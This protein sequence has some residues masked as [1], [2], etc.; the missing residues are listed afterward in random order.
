MGLRSAKTIGSVESGGTQRQPAELDASRLTITPNPNPKKLPP[1]DSP[2]LQTPKVTTDHRLTV[3][4]TEESGWDAPK[5]EPYGPLSLM[6][7]ASVLHYATECYEGLKAYRGYDGRVRLFR[8]ERNDQ[9]FLRSAARISLPAF[10]PGE[11]LKLLK[12]FVG[13]ETGKWL[14]APGRFIYIRPTLIGTAPTLGVNRPQEALMYI[15]LIMWPPLHVPNP[16]DQLSAGKS[17]YGMKLLASQQDMIRAWPGGIG[18][19]KVGANYGPT[20]VAHSEA[21]KSGYDQVLWLFGEECFV[22]EA[23]GT[24]MFVVFKSK[25]PGRKELVTPPLIDGTILEGV[26]RASVLD[27]AKGEYGHVYDVIERKLT[28]FELIEAHQDGRL[29][30]AFGTGTAYFVTSCSEIQF[31][32]HKIMVPVPNTSDSVAREIR[33]KLEDIMYGNVNHAWGVEVDENTV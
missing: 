33:Q 27:V 11:F 9:R 29:L 6:P 21:R 5:I 26:T 14:A 13:L 3:R 18:Y 7:T 20:F 17:T 1:H 28:M 23:G 8:P 25:Q 4:W 10:S 31:R 32:E 30:E 15:L 22:T 24:N 19:A 2:E 12:A 16:A